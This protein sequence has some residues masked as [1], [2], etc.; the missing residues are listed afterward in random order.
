MVAL[1]ACLP[2]RLLSV[3]EGSRGWQDLAAHPPNSEEGEAWPWGQGSCFWSI[4]SA[5]SLL[6]SLMATT[7]HLC[8]TGVWPHLI[9]HKYLSG[10]SRTHCWRYSHEQDRQNC[11]PQSLSSNTLC[12]IHTP[13]PPPPSKAG[14]AQAMGNW[15][16]RGG[17]GHSSESRGWRGNV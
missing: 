1:G 5:F 10:T 13:A 17:P 7:V 3:Q 16:G 2:R 8:N 14:W 4:G 15:E 9:I 11:H 12:C 6:G